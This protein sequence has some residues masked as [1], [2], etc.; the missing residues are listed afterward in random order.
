MKKRIEN[1][2]IS[3]QFIDEL[4]VKV[5]VKADFEMENGNGNSNDHGNLS[6]NSKNS[7][8]YIE[9]NITGRNK[10]KQQVQSELEQ[11]FKRN[12]S[13]EAPIAMVSI[14]LDQMGLFWC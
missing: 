8:Q 6:N 14:V 1:R 4:K 7:M 3:K 12:W 2:Q 11:H 13:N 5:R 10:R 9:T